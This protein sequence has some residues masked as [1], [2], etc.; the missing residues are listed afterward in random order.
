MDWCVLNHVT[1]MFSSVVP[2]SR[3]DSVCTVVAWSVS[4]VQCFDSFPKKD[5]EV[6]SQFWGRQ[7]KEP[8]FLERIVTLMTLLVRPRNETLTLQWKT[9]DWRKRATMTKWK[10]EAMLI[11]S[12]D[13][14]GI[15]RSELV[16][17]KHTAKH[18]SFE[19][20]NVTISWRQRIRG[21]C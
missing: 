16:L 6:Y 3:W 4:L 15:I 14:N 11:C 12:L 18:F 2:N 17:P 5:K 1:L 10:V 7:W 19:F 13:I 21:K 20:W 8:D 9:P